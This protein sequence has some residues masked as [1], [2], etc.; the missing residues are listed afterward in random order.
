MTTDTEIAGN[1]AMSGGS[2]DPT[3]VAEQLAAM[4]DER[5]ALSDRAVEDAELRETVESTDVDYG[6]IDINGESIPV[7]R[8]L[9]AGRRF[10]IAKQAATADERDDRMSQ[11]DA[12]LK[13]VD[14]LDDSTPATHSQSF[15]DDLADDA[16]RDAYRQLGQQSAGGAETGN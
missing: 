2:G 9:G 14:A 13:M 3:F 16:L 15:W 12:V 10:R 8:P 11:I 7:E 5:T 4:R 6:T 1:Y